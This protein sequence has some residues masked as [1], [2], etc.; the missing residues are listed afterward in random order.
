M[1]GF[2]LIGKFRDI[3]DALALLVRIERINYHLL[4]LLWGK[5]LN[6][7]DGK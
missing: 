4:G 7:G 1:Q 6:L 2:V 3:L 5:T